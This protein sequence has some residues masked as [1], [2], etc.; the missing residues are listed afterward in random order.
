MQLGTLGAGNHY[1]EMQIVEEIYDPAAAQKMGID[2]VGQV[3]DLQLPHKTS[4]LSRPHKS[5]ADAHTLSDGRTFEGIT[6]CHTSASCLQNAD[7]PS[8]PVPE[9]CW[10]VDRCAS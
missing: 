8:E 1:A 7:S 4:V 3:R 10:C 2:K 6:W 5:T 9:P